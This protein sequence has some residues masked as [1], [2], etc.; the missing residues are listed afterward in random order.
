MRIWVHGWDRSHQ[1]WWTNSQHA[2]RIQWLSQAGEMYKMWAYL[3]NHMLTNLASR[4]CGMCTSCQRRQGRAEPL[5]Y[6]LYTVV[7]VWLRED[8]SREGVLLWIAWRLVDDT[9]DKHVTR[10][11]EQA[12]GCQ[13]V[14]R[15]KNFLTRGLG[16]GA[17]KKRKSYKVRMLVADP[18]VRNTMSARVVSERWDRRLPRL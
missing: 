15:E 10:K 5:Q 17:P 9:A 2:V 3:G 12:G 8:D 13:R 1:W 4:T 16:A 7:Q 14:F 18:Q 6:V 11:I